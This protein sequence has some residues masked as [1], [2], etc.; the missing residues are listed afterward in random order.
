MDMWEINAKYVYK[1]YG[2]PVDW[3]E[4]F[5]I[6]PECGEPIYKDDWE[7]TGELSLFMCPICEFTS[8]EDDLDF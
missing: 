1:I 2:M 5:Y 6:C 8:E 7:E 4:C 3:E